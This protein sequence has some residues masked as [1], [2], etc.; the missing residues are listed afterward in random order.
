MP[1][2][3]QDVKI[4]AVGLQA[5]APLNGVTQ[6]QGDFTKL[7]TA[8]SIIEHFGGEDQKAQLVIKKIRVWRSQTVYN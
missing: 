2:A 5:M 7:S 8:Q 1:K 3:Y 6:I 4:I